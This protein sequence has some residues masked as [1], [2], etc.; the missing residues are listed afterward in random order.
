VLTQLAVGGLGTGCIYAL[1]GLGF[2]LVYR[3]L[4][5]V[6]F[7]QGQVFMAGT[8]LGL[9]LEAQFGLPALPLLLAVAALFFAV[10]LAL[11]RAVFRRLY[12][13]HEVFVVGTIG[14]GVMLENGFRMAYPEAM[15]FP[16]IFGL[17]VYHLGGALFQK[18]YLWIIVVTLALV[19]LLHLLF[20]HTRTGRN[21]RAVASDAEIAATL[22]VSVPRAMGFTFGLSFAVAAVAGVLIGPLYFVSPD[23]GDLVGLKAFA[24]AVL[25]GIDSVIGT[26]LGGL[27]LGLAESF[28]AFY[29]SSRY[30]DLIAFA[31]LMVM[32]VVRPQGL[33]GRARLVKV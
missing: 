23:S 15:A 14:L 8:F 18:T 33:L 25:G 22:G 19:A 26:I 10:G 4:T 1:V 31:V 9:I 17:G 6:N 20:A 24:A 3:T 30:Q 5:M 21:L 7:A 2:T 12:A 13:S 16:K 29:I 28:G 11:E 32:I 27:V